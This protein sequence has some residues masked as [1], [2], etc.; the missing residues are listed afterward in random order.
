MVTADCDQRIYFVLGEGGDNLVD[1]VG[2][3]QRIG[4]RGAQDRAAA[5][6]NAGYVRE[7]KWHGLVLEK[8]APAFQK[9]YEF[10]FVVKTAFADHGADDGVQPW[11]IA[12]AGQNADSHCLLLITRVAALAQLG[13]KRWKHFRRLLA[14]TELLD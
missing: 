9:S 3:L 13:Q 6:Q 12:S 11:T 8:A 1:S 10:I 14:A 7:I 2:P 4:A 5:G